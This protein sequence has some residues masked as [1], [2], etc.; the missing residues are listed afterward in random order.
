M[1]VAVG[2]EIGNVTEQYRDVLVAPRNHAASASY[3]VGSDFRQQ[4]VQQLIG[5]LARLLGPDQRFLQ[6]EMGSAPRASTMG[7]ENGLWM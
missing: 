2:G 1:L 5:L 4:R 3:L 6:C 7:P